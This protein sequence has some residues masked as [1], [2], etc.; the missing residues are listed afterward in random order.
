[1]K[2]IELLAVDTHIYLIRGGEESFLPVTTCYAT[3]CYVVAEPME[4]KLHNCF[5]QLKIKL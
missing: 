2:H 4:A 1:M 3:E 5:E